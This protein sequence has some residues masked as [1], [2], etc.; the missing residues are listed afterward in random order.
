MKVTMKNQPANL[1]IEKLIAS[2][3]DENK[4]LKAMLEILHKIPLSETFDSSARAIFDICKSMT[5]ATCGYVALLSEEGGENEVLFLDDGGLPCTVDPNLPMP[6]RGLRETAYNN[7]RVAYDNDFDNS[8]WRHLM[9]SGHVKL[10]NVL[11]APLNLAEKTAGVIGLA[12]KP[13]GFS[14]HDIKI[15]ETF[16]EIAA[17]AYSAQLNSPTFAMIN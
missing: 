16:G 1:E 6:I 15:A 9:P 5:K 4:E 8:N 17:L 3:V 7:G 2:L 10:H 11:F 13:G 14:D 12:N